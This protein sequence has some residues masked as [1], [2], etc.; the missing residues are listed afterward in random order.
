MAA[1]AQV[2]GKVTVDDGGIWTRIP[3]HRGSAP[4]AIPT[5]TANDTMRLPS[6]GGWLCLLNLQEFLANPSDAGVFL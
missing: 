6:R 2:I 3:P 5:T 1:E 4:E